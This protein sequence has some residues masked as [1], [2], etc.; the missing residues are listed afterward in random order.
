MIRTVRLIFIILLMLA[1]GIIAVYSSSSILGM[2]RFGDEAHFLKRHMINMIIGFVFM[3]M[4]WKMDYHNWRKLYLPMLVFTLMLLIL[5]FLPGFG[6]RAEGA[7]RWISLMGF[8][9]QPAELAKFSFIVY[10]A[11]SI[12]RKG[13]KMKSFL[14]GFLPYLIVMMP[15]L[16]LI[17]KEPD[18]G[19]CVILIL[20]LITMVLAGGLR[21]RY[22]FASCLAAFPLLYYAIVNKSYRMR[23]ILAFIDPWAD[24]SGYG[25]QIIQSFIAFGS[26]GLFGVGPGEGKQKLFYIPQAHT[27]FIFSVIAEEYGF[28]GVLLV[29]VLFSLFVI[30]GFRIA[31]RINDKFG[32]L[33]AIGI[34]SAIGIQAFI[35]MSVV[36]GLL[37]PKGLTLPFISYGGSSLIVNMM[38][39]GV[40][41]SIASRMEEK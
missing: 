1:A 24:P 10:L 8:S 20:I 38:E 27:D 3:L 41:M 19:T 25:F 31:L 17:Y 21:L 35:H 22:L 23:R 6:K 33:L 4:C 15:F 9:F 34:T 2:K 29:I 12:E 36:M 40:L 39:A 32:C 26:G 14:Y 28:L 18:L 7:R 37:P 13:E 11:H 5:V 30:E 16:L